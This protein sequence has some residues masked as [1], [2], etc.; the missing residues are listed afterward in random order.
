MHVFNPRKIGG[1]G[2][3][4]KRFKNS[5]SLFGDKAGGGYTHTKT[6]WGGEEGWSGDTTQ[7]LK[8]LPALPEI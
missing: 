8:T 6:G 5:R 1:E 7:L 2:G 4:D 3:G